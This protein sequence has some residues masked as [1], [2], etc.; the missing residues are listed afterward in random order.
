M[1]EFVVNGNRPESPRTTT[2]GVIVVYFTHTKFKKGVYRSSWVD[3][4]LPG[5]FSA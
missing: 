1:D 3:H 4:S 5:F 2:S